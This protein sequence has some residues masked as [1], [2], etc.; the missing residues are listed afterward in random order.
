VV[1]GVEYDLL[2]DEHGEVV[3][4]VDIRLPLIH[5][6]LDLNTCSYYFVAPSI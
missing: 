4:L 3:D 1:N 5:L 6:T 2:P